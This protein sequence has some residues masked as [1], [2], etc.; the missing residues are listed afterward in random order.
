MT[1][2]LWRSVLRRF[3]LRSFVV[4]SVSLCSFLAWADESFRVAKL[5]ESPS[6]NPDGSQ[7][8]FAWGGDV[9][10]V[11]SGGGIAQKLTSELSNETQPKFSPDGKQIAFVSDRNGPSQIYVMSAEGGVPSQKSFHSEDY[12]LADWFPDGKSVLAIAARDHFWRNAERMIQVNVEQRDVEKV[13]VDAHVTGAAVSPNGKMLLLTREGE[14]WWR[15]GYR[16]E[17]ASQIWSYDLERKVFTELL[18]EG[19]ECRSPVWGRNNR[20]FYFT[21]GSDDGFALWQYRFPK[22]A[23]QSPK[24]K[25]LIGFD[26]D[27]IVQPTVSRDGKVLVFRHLFDLYVYRFGIDERPS[28]IDIRL[29]ENALRDDH[30][31]QVFNKANEVAFSADGL[32]MAFKAGGDVWIMDTELKEPVQATRTSGEERDLVFSPDGKSLLFVRTTDGQSDVWKMEPKDR[33][34]PWWQQTEFVETRISESMETE[35]SLRFTHDG[36]KLVYEESDGDLLVRDLATG[37]TAVLHDGFSAYTFSISP[38]NKWV[39]YA[40]A[41]E[42]FNRDVWLVPIDRSQAPINVSRHPDN[43]GEPVFSPDGKILAFTGTR[44]DD[45]VDIYYVYLEEKLSD[46]SSRDRRLAKA[47]ETVKKKRFSAPDSKSKESE[48]K[49]AS[50]LLQ[51]AKAVAETWLKPIVIDLDGIHLRV[52]KIATSNT[53]DR[54]LIFSPDSKKLAF[55]A[56]VDGKEGTYYVEFPDRLQPKLLSATTLTHAQWPK[57]A[58]AILGLNKGVPARLEATDKLTTFGFVAKHEASK[59]GRFREGFSAAWQV[60]RDV[61]YDAKL[62]QRNW[63]EIRRKYVEVASLAPDAKSFTT[64]VEMMLGELNGSHLGFT[65]QAESSP[66]SDAKPTWRTEVAHLGV[67]FVDSYNGPGLLVRDVLPNGPADKQKSRLVAGDIILS[68]DGTTV[69]PRSDLTGLLTGTLDRDIRLQVRRSKETLEGTKKVAQSNEFSATIRPITYTQARELLYEHWLNHNRGLVEKGSNGKLGYLHIKLMDT[70]S[71]HEFETQLYRVGYG[72]EGL[73]ID[74]RDNRGGSTT[75][76]L[77]TALTQPQHAFTIPR[78]G[79]PGYPQDRL[80]FATWSKPIVVLC[81]QNSFSNAEIFSHAIKTLGRGKL[82][83]VQTAGGVVS[84]GS[85]TITDLGTL[86]VP[87]RGWFSIESGEDMELNGA[88]PDFILWPQPNEIPTGIDKQLELAIEVLRD[89]V[90]KVKPAVEARYT[91]QR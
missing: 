39:A 25:E 37:E 15:K 66:T 55:E 63:D 23:E 60:M 52:R 1:F 27:S 19:F 65:S 77:L 87:F 49:G 44:E 30:L 40:T 53:S 12:Q 43:D 10:R 22:S 16:G 71:F 33:K 73:V 47:F 67:R 50:Q 29:Q 91:T 28:R 8:V 82:I 4:Y 80:V 32:D 18:H 20:S 46:E 48:S 5:M 11:N 85:T 68:I 21:K 45:E 38:D 6:L 76:Y 64:V 58:D 89:E 26:E 72:R 75:D 31:R 34:S 14:R 81:N 24:S 9:W 59:S 36:K 83:G 54:G 88:K 61:W 62:G 90:S 42:Y 3:I 69:D 86:R 78:N 79:V 7:L 74:V 57:A 56:K 41:D 35:R 70:S 13:L 84:T 17:R 2:N 51:K